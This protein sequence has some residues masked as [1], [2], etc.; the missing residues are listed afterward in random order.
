MG[1]LSIPRLKVLFLAS[2]YPSR[3][4]PLSGIFIKKKAMALKRYCDVAV[5]FISS[6]PGMK[7]KK[8]E[9]E[10]VREDGVLTIRVFYRRVPNNP[11]F[12]PLKLFR[13]IKG[14]YLGLRAVKRHFGRPDLIH[15]NVISDMGWMAVILKYLKGIPFVITEHHDIWLQMERRYTKKSLRKVLTARFFVKESAFTTVDSHAMKRALEGLGFKGKI[16]VVPNV[17]DIPLLPVKKEIPQRKRLLH[18]SL[19]SP[20]KNVEGIIKAVASLYRERKDFELHIM[21]DGPRRP[22][23][24][25]V[26]KEEGILKKVV[27]FHGMVDEEEKR[28]FLSSSDVF[29]LNSFVEGFSIATAEALWCGVPCVVTRCGGPEDFVDEKCGIF[30][31]PGNDEELKNAIA[32]VLDNLENY[33]RERIADEIRSRFN[34]VKVAE[35]LVE[36]YL[37]TV[38]RW[39]T[40]YAGKVLNIESRWKV[41]D[42]GSGDNPFRRADVLLEKELG[43]SIHREGEAVIPEGKFMVIGDAEK[44]PFKTGAFDYAVASHILEHLEHPDA[45]LS[46]L[47]RVAKAGYIE[48]PGPLSD[49]LLNETYHL[50]R[51][52]RKGDTLYLSRKKQFALPLP[53]FYKI[54]YLNRN[55]KRPTMKS[56]NFFL[57]GVSHFLNRIWKFLPFTYTTLEWKERVKY[58]ILD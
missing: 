6:D 43:K 34:P 41:L 2:W 54:F 44:M 28:M 55:C 24:E 30:V 42:V 36:I 53:F 47:S 26:A 45:F 38:K 12:L 18:I 16:V 20:Q 3:L 13:Y 7:G 5:L 11:L 27:F 49:F 37:G 50:W 33:D 51:V 4:H 56:N 40:G 10:V 29:V 21:G 58:R 8:Y 32:F 31:Q 52:W 17:V 23:L 46:E 1:R 39:A 9:T 57:K 25:G 22:F 48:T 15:L 19:L 35:L 14:R